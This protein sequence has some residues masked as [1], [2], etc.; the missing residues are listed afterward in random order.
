MLVSLVERRSFMPLDL[1]SSM[2]LVFFWAV[3]VLVLDKKARG[4][5]YCLGGKIA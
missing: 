4:K 2:S 5:G 3:T 1:K